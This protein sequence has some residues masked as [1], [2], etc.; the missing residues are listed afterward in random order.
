MF[1]APNGIGA[2]SG[3]V[4]LV[5]YVKYYKSTTKIVEGKQGDMELGMTHNELSTDSKKPSNEASN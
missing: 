1:Q 3:L 5:L 4:Q 2:V